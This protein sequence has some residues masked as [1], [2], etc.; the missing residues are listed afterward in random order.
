MIKFSDNRYVKENTTEYIKTKIIDEKKRKLMAAYRNISLEDLSCKLGI[1]IDMLKRIEVGTKKSDNVFQFYCSIFKIPSDEIKKATTCNGSEIIDYLYHQKINIIIEWLEYV[2]NDAVFEQIARNITNHNKAMLL[3]FLHFYCN[4]NYID[5]S[6]RRLERRTNKILTDTMK[7]YTDIC[8]T[9]N[10]LLSACGFEYTVRKSP[11][12]TDLI[13]NSDTI[14]DTIEFD[15]EDIY[16]LINNSV[17]V[18][19]DALEDETIK[20]G[21][22][23]KQ[24]L[25]D[26]NILVTDFEEKTG[27]SHTHV[28]EIFN[29]KH[30]LND[31]TLTKI[32]KNYPEIF[33]IIEKE[34]FSIAQNDEI[35][36]MIEKLLF[37]KV[38]SICSKNKYPLLTNALNRSINSYSLDYS[39]QTEYFLSFFKAPDDEMVTIDEFTIDST[40]FINN[41]VCINGAMRD[42][43]ARIISSKENKQLLSTITGKYCD[44]RYNDDTHKIEIKLNVPLLKKYIE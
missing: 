12:Y 37:D 6:N 20:I 28:Y 5:E 26:F 44:V 23:L 1:S 21:K 9:T 2:V 30:P 19:N 4:L 40:K 10:K 43:S 42:I 29:G 8:N 31:K 7:L 3:L 36:K 13:I 27:I 18:D 39:E 41:R 17:N 34:Y 11:N 35:S 38:V 16:L 22:K 24:V 32:E 14:Q 15:F 25:Q 33:K